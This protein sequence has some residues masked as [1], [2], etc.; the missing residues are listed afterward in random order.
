MPLQIELILSRMPSIRRQLRLQS[1][2]EDSGN[3]F[4]EGRW[5]NHRTTPGSKGNLKRVLFE[6]MS[7]R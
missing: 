6:E 5:R 3:S 4:G 1:L 7:H 2:I